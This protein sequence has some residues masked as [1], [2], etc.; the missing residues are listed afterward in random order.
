MTVAD[1]QYGWVAVA[2]WVGLHPK[3]A[4]RGRWATAAQLPIVSGTMI[5]V[6]VEHLPQ[7][8]TRAVKTL[9]LWWAGP[10]TPELATCWWAYLRRFD[11]EHTFRFAKHT[12]GWTTPR[13]RTPAQADR[14]T[15]LIVSAYS[16]LRLARGQVA[17]IR[18]PR[19][20]PQ[21]PNRLTPARVRRGFRRLHATLG[22]PA[23]PAKP[24][25]P[26]PGRPKG[27]RRGPRTRHPAIKR[28]A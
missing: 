22:T 17:D 4:R 15:W 7:P 25:R 26:G 3:L 2:A 28:A 24:S 18:L 14:W 20:R 13:V 1:D 11:L 21:H 9:W 8:T 12:L 23:S 27:S 16:Q 10:G 19:H 5:R 6:Q